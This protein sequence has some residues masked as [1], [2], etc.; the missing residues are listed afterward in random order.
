MISWRWVILTVAAVLAFFVFSA[1]IPQNE[2]FHRFADARTIFGMPNFWNV[3]SNLPF[4]IVGILGLCR[5]RGTTDRV[6]FVGILFTGFG[7]AWYHLAPTDVSLV[8]DRL[9]M[10]VVF[11]SFLAAVIAPDRLALL[12][13]FLAA[14]A[15][16]VLWWAATNNLRPYGVIKFGPILLLAPLLVRSE[17]RKHLMVVIVLFG[18]AQVLELA[19]PAMMLRFALSGHT[20]KHLVATTA[21]WEIYRWR[22]ICLGSSAAILPE[23]A[24]A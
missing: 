23:P 13:S 11:M 17:H 6:V 19:D 3:I 21:T 5:F 2:A 22:R 24:Q 20:L 7:S 18:L 16:S 9:P 4:I 14:G 10:T 1:P 8:W 12:V 15:G